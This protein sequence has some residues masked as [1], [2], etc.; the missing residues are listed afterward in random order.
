MPWTLYSRR[1]ATSAAARVLIGEPARSDAMLAEQAGVSTTT[2]GSVRARLEQVGV[3]PR[4]PAADRLARPRPQRP[5]ATAL[6]ILALGPQA[7]PRQI[8]DAASVSM[9]AAW[10]AWRKLNPPLQDCAA[11]TDQLT[12]VKMPRML[13]DLAA[14]ADS[15]SVSATATC[16]QCGQ[17]FPVSTRD[18]RRR[19][20]TPACADAAAEAQG[21]APKPRLA[22]PD[23]PPPAIQPLPRP[24]DWSRGTC[25]H[26]PPSQQS[27]WTSTDPILREAAAHICE[28]CPILLPCAE[29]SLALPVTDNA[30][31]AGMSQAERLRR[32]REERRLAAMDKPS[33]RNLR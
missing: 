18:Y 21:H 19:Y 14:A 26:V 20:C 22:D 2:I 31:W 12:V 5:S 16:A 8:A 3:I 10:K 23:H 32:K 6:A 30:I 29:F 7:T 27:W 24:P 17:P 33:P 28:T 1:E 25:A 11:A 9:Q 13:D 4:V 15:I